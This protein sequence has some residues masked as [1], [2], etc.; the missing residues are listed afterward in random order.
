[1]FNSISD[2]HKT[3][4]TVGMFC[5][6]QV[7]YEFAFCQSNPPITTGFQLFRA[8]PRVH[9]PMSDT[10]TLVEGGL[11]SSDMLV[12][13]CN[14]DEEIESQLHQFGDSETIT[15]EPCEVCPVVVTD[16]LTFYMLKCL[17]IS[18]FD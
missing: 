9:V 16:T 7:L 4:F 14:E 18:I 2:C 8:I 10:I 17:R 3:L 1:M 12:V 5:I 15:S 11:C 13:E 6:T